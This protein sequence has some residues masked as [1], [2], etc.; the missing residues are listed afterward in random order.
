M[1]GLVVSARAPTTRF[2]SAGVRSACIT[3]W[4][5]AAP[6]AAPLGSRSG[7][8]REATSTRLAADSSAR[9]ADPWVDARASGRARAP[10]ARPA[11]LPARV[12]PRDGASDAAPALR[13]V[14]R[15]AARRG[16]TT[17][18]STCPRSR[19]RIKFRRELGFR[20]SE[21]IAPTRPTNGSRPRG[22]FASP[23][24]RRRADDRPRAAPAPPRLC[25]NEPAASCASATSS[26]GRGFAERIERGPGR[27][28]VSNA[29]FVYLRD[30]DGHRIE[31]YT[32][33]YYTGDPDHEPIAGT[34]DPPR[35][36]S[37]AP[38]APQLVRG[39]LGDRRPRRHPIVATHDAGVDER[40]SFRAEVAQLS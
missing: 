16:S 19:T 39:V 15:R 23:R 29:F 27:H 31:L 8:A 11:R 7:S 4:C 18:T 20:C 35:P 12:L 14:P 22:C 3:A 13:P 40:D 9:A 2:I 5:C 10:R 17:S 24:A 6:A 36:T 33:D 1:L 30:P 25:V 37:G 28:G 38:A 32:G 26:P 21:Y 34:A